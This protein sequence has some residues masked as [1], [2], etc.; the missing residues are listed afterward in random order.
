[1]LIIIALYNYF[2]IQIGEKRSDKHKYICTV[3][4][5]YLG[6]GGR[7]KRG[8]QRMR[9]RDGITDSMD[10]SLSEL[11]EFVLRFMGSRRVRHDW[12]TELNWTDIVT[13]TDPFHFFICIWVPGRP[14]I[15]AWRTCFSSYYRVSLLMT[16]SV[17]I[18][19][20]IP[21]SFLKDSFAA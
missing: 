7:R 3:F 20:A 4:Y 8:R 13:F 17:F 16:G 15:S 5:T 10:M 2:L 6:I 19:W 14:L 18:C 21:S 11:R 9:W 1:M 12:A